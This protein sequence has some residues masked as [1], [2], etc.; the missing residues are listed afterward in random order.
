[1]RGAGLAT[2]ATAAAGAAH[3]LP[4]VVS[5]GQWTPLRALPG[6]LCRWRGPAVAKVALTFDDGPAPATT[7]AVLDRLDELDLTATFFC[8]GELAALEPDLVKELVRRGHQVETH[9]YRHEHH[10]VHSPRWVVRDLEEALAALAAVGVHPSWYR[11]PYG[12]T[13]SGT[14]LAAQRH[15]LRLALWSAWG[16]EWVPS[17]SGAVARRVE[18][19]LAPGAIVLLHDTDAFSPAGSVSRMLGALGP[20][21]EALHAR[22]LEAVAL[23]TLVDAA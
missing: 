23:D 12:Q 7:P 22:G 5:L 11:P 20:I 15:H 10:F 2:A 13:T 17:D 1:V 16:R 4:S 14:L 9:G 3:M 8:I 19:A 6:D 21:A 18:R